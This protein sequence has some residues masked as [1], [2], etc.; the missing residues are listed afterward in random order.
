MKQII[1]YIA[2]LLLLLPFKTKAQQQ[3]PVL[4]LDSILKKIDENNLLLQ[5]YGLKAASY[6]YMADAATAWMAPMVGAGTFM[7]PY[8]GQK[9][10]DARDNGN[11]MLQ[12]EQDIPNPA[13]LNAK[14]K[15][16][17]SQADIELAERD[18]S[19]NNFKAQAKKIYYNWLIAKNKIKVLQESERIMTTMKK[20]EEV[21]YP[22]N[23]SQLGNIYRIEAKIEGNRNM[24]NMQEGII[25]KA[26]AWLNSLMNV[27]GN[28]IFAID[29]TYEP[30]FA[31]TGTFD[32]AGLASIR[33]DVL[34]VSQN[35]RSMQLNIE[36]IRKEKKPDFRIRFDHMNPLSGM[37]PKA[38][39]VMGMISIPI[40]PWASKMYKSSVKAIEYNI[41][42]MEKERAGI[43]QETQA[44][45]YGMQYEI[46]TMHNRVMSMEEKIVPAL[47][48]AMDANFLNYQENKLGLPAV[49]DSWEALNMMQ[50]N[51]LD[52]KLKHYEM[53]VDYEKELYR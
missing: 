4:T 8:P 1:K 10:N 31:P 20:I 3:L 39:S 11:I 15:Y 41:A 38:F 19:L 51:V 25:A 45:I 50:I 34:K 49:M 23:Q 27:N 16:I 18:V 2:W 43:L 47:Q 24:I 26:M 13:K 32:T 30:H 12:I 5:S 21:R 35:I 9:L 22:Y 36:S 14:K 40:A 52:E 29:S 33:K 6:K 46:Q 44:M 42:G 7:T 48:K 53:I 17:E 37:M 28:E